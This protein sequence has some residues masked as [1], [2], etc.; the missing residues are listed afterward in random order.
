M[1]DSMQ[2]I[3]RVITIL[4]PDNQSRVGLGLG[5]AVNVLYVE[6]SPSGSIISLSSDASNNGGS[7]SSSPVSGASQ[8]PHRTQHGNARSP[9]PSAHVVP[10][11]SVGSASGSSGYRAD[12]S[13]INQSGSSSSAVS[14]A[15]SGGPPQQGPN[16]APNAGVAHIHIQHNP[17]SDSDAS[18]SVVP[19]GAS[20]SGAGRSTRSSKSSRSSSNLFGR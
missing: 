10:G 14:L 6:G 13:N 2:E 7:V 19:S 3:D 11:P 17:E 20:N 16:P 9:P 15:S 5:L 18:N 4:L 8:L 12:S 1:S